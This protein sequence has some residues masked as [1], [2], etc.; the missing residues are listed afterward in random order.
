MTP[1]DWGRAGS[2]IKNEYKYLR[3]FA[4]EI[5]S[6]KQLL[7]GRMTQRATQY[8]QA[9]RHTY[10]IAMA[11]EQAK[12]GYDYVRSVLQANESCDGCIQQAGLRWQPIGVMIP[13]GERTCLRNCRC[14]V[15]F[16]NSQTGNEIGPF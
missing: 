16:R 12:R 13:I 8:A 4:K 1:S 2:L 11:N 5:A 7:D 9:S 6:G 3:N 14:I 15:Y 10:Y